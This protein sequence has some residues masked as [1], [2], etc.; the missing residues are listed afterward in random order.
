MLCSR[1]KWL[2]RRAAESSSVRRKPEEERHDGGFRFVQGGPATKRQTL[3][4]P[5]QS[6]PLLSAYMCLAQYPGEE[7]SA[8]VSLVGIGYP[9]R[10]VPPEHELMSSTRIRSF[11]PR[12]PQ[13][14]N[15]VMS[16]D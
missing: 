15:Q 14:A 2:S 5:L 6:F 8:D 3:R 7:F 1:G 13:V 12:E 4:T 11:K 9:D 16:L 10:C